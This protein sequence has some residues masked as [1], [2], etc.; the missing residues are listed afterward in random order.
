MYKE[1]REGGRGMGVIQTA[2]WMRMH[3][4]QPEKICERFT[5]YIPLRKEVLYR[6]LISKGMFRPVEDGEKEIDILQKNQ[7]WEK[8]EVE[9][10]ALKKWLNGPDI[11]VFIL[12]SD[13]Y[14][15]TVQ[16]EYN[17]KA[18][19]SMRGALFLFVSPTNTIEELRALLTHEYHHICR[20]Y[21]SKKR[22][23]GYTLLDTMIMEGLAEQAVY[24]RYSALCYAPWTAY[25]E[26]EEAIDFWQRFV[27]EKYLVKRGTREH[28]MILNGLGMYPKMLGYTIG[29]HI[30]K[31]CVQVGKE[32]TLSLLGVEA[33][34]ILRKASSF[35]K[36]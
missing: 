7:V 23:E 14:N 10:K 6:F 33:E 30:V 9:Y 2:E 3:Y 31:D 12:L 8:L 17:G 1:K 28:D 19:L 20:L 35:C 29:F 4:Q 32:D 15:K 13:P 26:K 25:Y 36:I 27:K 18:G 24:E 5:K 34:E 21:N 11:P 22:E 16:N